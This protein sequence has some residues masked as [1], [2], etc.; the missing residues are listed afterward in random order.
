MKRSQYHNRRRFIDVVHSHP[1][2]L[3]PLS[4]ILI[5]FLYS[6]VDPMPWTKAER[7]LD[8][9]GACP[10]L[11]IP[12][13]PVP[14]TATALVPANHPPAIT[15]TEGKPDC[16]PVECCGKYLTTNVER[17]GDSVTCAFPPSSSTPPFV[18]S[19]HTSHKIF[20][21]RVPTLP[22]P[23]P[24]PLLPC[25]HDTLVFLVNHWHR[26]FLHSASCNCLWKIHALHV[27][28][29]L[30]LGVEEEGEV[31]ND[32]FSG[33]TASAN[34]SKNMMLAARFA[35]EKP[36]PPRNARICSNTG[37]RGASNEVWVELDS[38]GGLAGQVASNWKA[39]AEDND[40]GLG[41]FGS[42]LPA[43][44]RKTAETLWDLDEVPSAT[45]LSPSAPVITSGTTQPTTKPKN[46]VQDPYRRGLLRLPPLLHLQRPEQ[47]N[48]RPTASVPQR[49]HILTSLLHPS[50]FTSIKQTTRKRDSTSQLMISIFPQGRSI[51]GSWTLTTIWIIYRTTE[52]T[53]WK[54]N[55]RR[56]RR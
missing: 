27:E 15:T 37:L 45:S 52:E 48:E 47:P 41:E 50:S 36:P 8:G 1:Q 43:V 55:D 19:R 28:A 5:P 49:I 20:H 46:T 29:L 14:T 42:R 9:K 2:F 25:H 24:P 53:E 56:R 10:S 34:G 33:S 54:R 21:F 22:V 26:W 6:V 31:F 44:S 38:L 35:L 4:G 32:L 30:R 18:L 11:R 16:C 39:A 51:I 13:H 3:Y 40:W 7:P 23:P 12:P 17:S